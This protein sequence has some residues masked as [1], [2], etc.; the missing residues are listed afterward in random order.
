M[1]YSQII[2]FSPVTLGDGIKAGV[3]R[4]LCPL[5]TLNAASLNQEAYS[6][7]P[8]SVPG[9]F[10]R[11]FI[12]IADNT[13]DGPSSLAVRRSRSD[14]AIVIPVNPRQL[15][16]IPDSGLS[17]AFAA[18]DD[19]SWGLDTRAAANG[20]INPMAVAL[21]FLPDDPDQ[22]VSWAYTGGSGGGFN[23]NSVTRYAS[24]SG[25]IDFQAN[26]AFAKSR[27]HGAFIVGRQGVEIASNSRVTPIVF[28]TR[29]NG[30]DG[31]QIITVP[32]GGI[33]RFFATGTFDVLSPGD[34]LNYSATTGAGG[35][36]FNARWISAP[37]IS[38]ARQWVYAATNVNAAAIVA[39]NG[40]RF[41]PFAGN[42]A[43]MHPSEA[44]AMIPT[45]AQRVFGLSAFVSANNTTTPTIVRAGLNGF[46]CCTIA[47]GQTGW[48]EN[49]TDV[50]EIA[51][52]GSA[53]YQI[54]PGGGP[55]QVI[56]RGITLIGETVGETY[57]PHKPILQV[58]D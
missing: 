53:H 56:F 31:N 7:L 11:G 16:A 32:P 36:N 50:H 29:I 14:T 24:I 39:A 45:F 9:R 19:L 47:P 33:G 34:T 25:T 10:D 46:S 35:G 30:L 20:L 15:G 2:G 26:E 17:V 41:I 57:A 13:L 58:I 48:I 54:I 43:N 22:T 38:S 28:R 4:A 21:R 37:L 55:G 52:G 49:L 42:L 44:L 6:Q 1:P 51:E 27:I 8:V 12:Q 3:R 40:P 23:A 18:L 5:N